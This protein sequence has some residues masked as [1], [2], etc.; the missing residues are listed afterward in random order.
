MILLT[1]LLISVPSRHELKVALVVFVSIAAWVSS[2]SRSISP[3]RRC[4]WPM[5]VCERECDSGG[6]ER[7]G[8]TIELEEVTRVGECFSGPRGSRCT[9]RSAGVDSAEK[10]SSGAGLSPWR[11]SR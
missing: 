10:S 7:F 11:P 9:P 6:R 8:D 4:R 2:S 1:A 5:S 3:R